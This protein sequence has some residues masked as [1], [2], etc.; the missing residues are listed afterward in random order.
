[1][2]RGADLLFHE[3]ISESGLANTSSRYQAYHRKSH[4]TASDLGRLAS[5]AKPGKLILYHALFY[6][7]PEARVV[8]EVRATYKGEV[9]LASDL[10]VF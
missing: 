7:V 5:E 1:M 6:G 2:A 8:D 9:V 10:D 3:V 4:T